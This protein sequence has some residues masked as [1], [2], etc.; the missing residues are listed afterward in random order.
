MESVLKKYR[1]IGTLAVNGFSPKVRFWSFFRQ[2]IY[3][4]KNLMVL[5]KIKRFESFIID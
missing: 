3:R 4:K 5:R 1:V 2:K